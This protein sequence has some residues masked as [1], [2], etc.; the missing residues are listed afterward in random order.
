MNETITKN[1]EDSHLHVKEP[2]KTTSVSQ[3]TKESKKRKQEYKN[4]RKRNNKF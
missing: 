1:D 4:K 2:K 3:R